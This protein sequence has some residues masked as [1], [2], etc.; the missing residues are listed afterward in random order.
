MEDTS[1]DLGFWA[2]PLGHSSLT[3]DDSKFVVRRRVAMLKLC[4]GVDHG[5]VLVARSGG[6]YISG[7]VAKGVGSKAGVM[8]CLRYSFVLLLIL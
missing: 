5:S 1:N 4:S 2:G 8:F 3:V 6:S 7:T